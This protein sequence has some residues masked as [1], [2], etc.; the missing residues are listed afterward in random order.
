MDG[1]KGNME[2][3]RVDMDAMNVKLKGLTKFVGLGDLEQ[4]SKLVV[5]TNKTLHYWTFWKQPT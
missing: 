4:G 2:V 1:I 3:F 5:P